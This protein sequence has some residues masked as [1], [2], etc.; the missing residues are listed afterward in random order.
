M[1]MSIVTRSGFSSR[2]RFTACT[3]SSASP[4]TVKPAVA[5][6]SRSVLRMKRASSTIR[7]RFAITPPPGCRW[8]AREGRGRS[9]S[10]VPPQGRPARAPHPGAPEAAPRRPAAARFRALRIRIAPNRLGPAAE[11]RR[12]LRAGPGGPSGRPAARGRSRRRRDRRGSAPRGAPGARAALGREARSRS[13]GAR[14]RAGSRSA[15]LRGGRSHAGPRSLQLEARDHGLQLDRDVVELLCR[16]GHLRGDRGLLVGS[17]Q[18]LVGAASIAGGH[19]LDLADG[20]DHLGRTLELLARRG[21]DDVDPLGADLGGA[22]DLVEREDDLRQVLAPLAQLLD[23]LLHR[24]HRVL[25]AL[26]DLVREPA[27]LLARGPG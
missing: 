8:P 27:D 26:T 12:G 13:P 18:D 2:N 17:A 16:A 22:H 19:A 25:A 23:A 11:E 15:G 5:K 24:R 10:L 3:P 20:L 21:E 6:M 7:T 14:P 9:A 4:A 1:T